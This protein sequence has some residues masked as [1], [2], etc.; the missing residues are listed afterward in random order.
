MQPLT[1]FLA[2]GADGDIIVV[3]DDA[4]LVHQ[5]NLLLIVAIQIGVASGHW[6]GSSSIKVNVGKESQDIVSCHCLS[7]CGRSAHV[8]ANNQ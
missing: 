8:A 1:D 6:G 4:Y 3:Q 2:G 5:P 7:L